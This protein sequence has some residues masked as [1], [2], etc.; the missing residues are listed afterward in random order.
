MSL[1]YKLQPL[2]QYNLSSGNGILIGDDF[3]KNVRNQTSRSS[4]RPF[5]NFPFLRH[6]KS[7]RIS[8]RGLLLAQMEI[9]IRI[10]RT[11]IK[12]QNSTLNFSSFA[13]SWNSGELGICR[14]C[15]R[16]LQNK[17]QKKTNLAIFSPWAF[18]CE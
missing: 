15:A 9:S 16:K 8:H 3:C 17:R 18:C 2:V 5:S 7:S 14:S 13:P 4:Q 11:S 10:S 12:K 6:E 1:L